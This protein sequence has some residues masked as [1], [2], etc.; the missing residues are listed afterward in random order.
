MK[1]G[2]TTPVEKPT[3][4]IYKYRFASGFSVGADYIEVN[5]WERKE[6]NELFY[7]NRITTDII[8]SGGIILLSKLLMKPKLHIHFTAK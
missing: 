4:E 8:L 7:D 3:A 2:P 6:A 1:T 5:V